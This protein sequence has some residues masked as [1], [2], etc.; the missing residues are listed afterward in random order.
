MGADL[1]LFNK[2]DA[3]AGLG[4]DTQPTQ[5]PAKNGNINGHGC[6]QTKLEEVHAMMRI[7]VKGLKIIMKETKLE[8]WMNT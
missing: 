5:T 4:N 1:N 6:D 8:N 3:L 7:R 2:V